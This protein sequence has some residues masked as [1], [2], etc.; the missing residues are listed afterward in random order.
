MKLLV[1]GYGNPGR[2]DDGLGIFFAEEIEKWVKEDKV[3][4][5]TVDSNYQL[6]AE[7]ALLMSEHD[8][9]IFADASKEKIDSFFIKEI[10]GSDTIA[11]T[12]HAMSPQS[13]ISLCEEM[14]NKKPKVYLISIKG[15]EWEVN[16]DMTT[17]AKENLKSALNKSKEFIKTLLHSN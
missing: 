14:Y 9:V 1:Y 17:E 16:E 10:E 4:G 8:V 3:E 7:D 11:F 2:Q 6:N 5:I 15:Y 12:T 13:V